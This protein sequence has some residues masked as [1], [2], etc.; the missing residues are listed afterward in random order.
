MTQHS[1]AFNAWLPEK[2]RL[3]HSQYSTR[4]AALL[5]SFESQLHDATLYVIEKPGKSIRPMLAFATAQALGLNENQALPIAMA[6]ESIHIYSLT[7]DDLPAM[8]DDDLRRGRPTCHKVY[9]DATAILVGDGLQALAFELIAESELDAAS[10]VKAM[11][12]LSRAAGIKG[13]VGGQML[14]IMA[15][16]PEAAAPTIE[17]LDRLHRLKTGAL[18]EASVTMVATL[19]VDEKSDT[20]RALQ[21]FA[22]LIGLAFQIQDD[23]LDITG[24]TATL[25]KPAGS[26]NDNDKLTYPALIGLESSKAR[27]YSLYDEALSTIQSLNINSA[28]LEELAKLIVWRSF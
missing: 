28:L 10:K 9:D 20:F 5:P 17:S 21:K 18:I 3:F 14:D 1:D 24:E 11:L 19:A 22:Q 15:S 23:I 8:D 12:T 16:S 25:G 27:L 26:D 7:H 2:Q 4:V 13:M 6:L